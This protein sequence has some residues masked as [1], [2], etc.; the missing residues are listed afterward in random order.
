MSVSNS[1]AAGSTSV[2][3]NGSLLVSSALSVLTGVGSSFFSICVSAWPDG[4]RRKKTPNRRPW[5]N[6]LAAAAG[7]MRLSCLRVSL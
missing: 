7:T 4:A 2:V 6:T 1:W 3:R 5:N